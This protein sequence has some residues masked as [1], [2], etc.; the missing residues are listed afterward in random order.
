MS[1]P[2]L[3]RGS[4][5]NQPR[6]EW[7]LFEETQEYVA[8]STLSAPARDSTMR[9]LPLLPERPWLADRKFEVTPLNKQVLV[10]KCLC[11]CM[12]PRAVC[13]EG[14]LR[15]HVSCRNV[16]TIPLFPPTPFHPGSFGIDEMLHVRKNCR[17][18][19]TPPATPHNIMVPYSQKSYSIAYLK[20]P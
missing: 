19:Q 16:E 10:C 14:C 4:T 11:Y 17:R 6:W 3:K 8:E 1:P 7:F 18:N 12:Q 2:M 15:Q 13:E 20:Q 9:P 5:C